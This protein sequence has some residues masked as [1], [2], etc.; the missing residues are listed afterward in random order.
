MLIALTACGGGAAPNPV[1]G[2]DLGSP[3]AITIQTI[4]PS[5]TPSPTPLKTAT[6]VPTASP[7][8]IGDSCLIGKW[9]LTSLVMKDTASVPGT[10]LT[11]T[12]QV[13]HT[14]QFLALG[15]DNAGNQ[16]QPPLGAQV[17][18]DDS[19]VNLGALPTVSQTTRDLGSPTPSS[20]LGDARKSQDPRFQPADDRRR[21]GRPHGD[22]PEI[23]RCSPAPRSR[24]DPF[25]A[26]IGEGAQAEPSAKQWAG[27]LVALES[28]RARRDRLREALAPKPHGGQ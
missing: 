8:A 13:G 10:T 2:A 3:R 15:T 14:Y 17:P 11:F 19:Q 6:P 20:A 27:I 4:A 16:E 7:V 18:A 25:G 28:D 12:G 23:A 1:G 26:P 9:T 22:L 5:P 24:E 21:S